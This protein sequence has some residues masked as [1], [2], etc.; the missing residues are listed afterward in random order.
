[1]RVAYERPFEEV[2]G[3]LLPCYW[4]YWEVGKHLERSGS[5]NPLYQKWIDTYASEE[6]AAVVQAVLDVADQVVTDLPES[7]RQPIRTHF[8]TTARYEWMF[9]D[10]AWRLERWPV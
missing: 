2:I 4:I 5:P 10:A 6:Y 1:L 8:V 9:W 7:R 3:A